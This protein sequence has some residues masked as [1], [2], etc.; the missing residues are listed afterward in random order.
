MNTLDVTYNSFHLKNTPKE[1]VINVLQKAQ[2][3]NLNPFIV[4][5][6]WGTESWF[7]QY[8]KQCNISQ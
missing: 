1:K 8:N 2:A 4:L 5:G 3:E 7:G 6:I